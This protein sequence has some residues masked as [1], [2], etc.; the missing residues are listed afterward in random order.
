MRG[1]YVAA[2]ALMVGLVAGCGEAVP[3]SPPP[4][5]A[6]APTTEGSPSPASTPDATAAPRATSVD[7]SLLTLLPDAI[8]GI[9]VRP[10]PETAA[11]IARDPALARDA[12]GLAVAL[13]IAPNE[14]DSEIAV[15]TVVRLRPD[16]FD[17]AFFT[18]WRE[19]YDEGACAQ[20]G[21]VTGRAVTGV[22]GH[23]T[24]IG[25]CQGGARTYHVH[26]PGPD[27][28]VSITALGQRRLGE[29]LVAALEPGG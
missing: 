26:L 15:A 7:A 29:K 13:V 16:V 10:D 4:S 27:V 22:E 11:D 25:T 12:A 1:R 3:D 9:V 17:E 6:V 2:A 8:E 14:V 19:T 21:G 28:L 24:H 5:I 23:M 18:A 20:A